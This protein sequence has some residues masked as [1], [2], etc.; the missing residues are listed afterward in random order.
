[1]SRRHPVLP[2]VSLSSPAMQTRNSNPSVCPP[3]SQLPLL[4]GA[5]RFPWSAHRLQ[6]SRAPSL[7]CVRGGG[8]AAGGDERVDTPAPRFSRCATLFACNSNPEQQSL[9][10]PPAA[11]SLYSREPFASQSLRTGFNFPAHPSLPCV[12]GGGSAKGG[13][14]RVDTPAP[15]FSRCVTFS[16]CTAFPGPQSLSLPSGQPAPFTQG[17]LSLPIAQLSRGAFALFLQL[18]A[19][20][21][22]KRA[23]VQCR[24]ALVFAVNGIQFVQEWKM[25]NPPLG[26]L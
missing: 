10:L 1:M 13:D 25:V 20:I 15:R 17:S 21:L 26:L 12:W 3:G 18:E 23:A 16:A 22:R 5:L 8:S 11:S 19:F 7:P 4:K 6:L 9:S 14:A 2:A 24:A